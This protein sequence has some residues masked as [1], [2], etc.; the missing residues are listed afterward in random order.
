MRF[1]FT[2]LRLFLHVAE[3]RSI[4]HG[5][6]RA[7]LALAS[8]SARIRGMEQALGVDLLKRDWRG[9]ALTAAG[10]SLVDHAR[11]VLQQVERLRGELG[12]HARGLKGRVHV[13][14][15]T[16]ALT[17]HLPGVLAS[18]L[19]ANANID[20]ELEER[21]SSDIAAAIASGQADIGIASDAALPDS[22]ERFPFRND[23]LVLVVPHGDKLTRCRQVWFRDV[24]DRDF[25]GLTRNSAL[26]RHLADHAA[27]LGSTLKLRVCVRGFDAVCRM[28]EAGAGVALVPETA[29]RRCRRSMAIGLVRVRDAWAERRLAVCTRALQA[30][31]VPARVLLEHLRQASDRR[32]T[33]A[34][35]LRG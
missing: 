7:N 28:V 4:T 24:I 14:T 11:L 21:E 20:I 13:L 26:Q 30:L 6:E 25:V 15:N 10:Q 16:A 29:A 31:P 1:D 27:R 34:R 3:A 9:V 18:F 33:T 17:E 23:R 12:A 32:L 2:D 35:T 5:A 22:V 8:A 19:S